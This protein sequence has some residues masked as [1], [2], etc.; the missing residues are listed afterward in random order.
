MVAVGDGRTRLTWSFDA[1]FDNMLGRYMGLM[2]DRWV[3]S[4]YVR[5]LERLKALAES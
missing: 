3:G 1:D 4:D 5:G 2:M